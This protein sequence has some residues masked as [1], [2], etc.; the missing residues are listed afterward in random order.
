[1][2]I[3]ASVTACL[4]PGFL[5]AVEL[6]VNVKGSEAKPLFLLE[7]GKQPSSVSENDK[8]L[9][10]YV[11]DVSDHQGDEYASPKDDEVTS[12]KKGFGEWSVNFKFNLDPK[13]KAGEYTFFAKWKQGGDPA[14]CKQTFAVFA[15][16]DASKLEE[17]GKFKLAYSKSWQYEWVMGGKVNF[18][19]DDAVVEIRNSGKAH[20]AKVFDAFI[21]VPK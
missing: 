4:M 7:L 15:G 2:L 14:A 1:M 16:A 21:L 19:A 17:R 13:L 6:P 9:Q 20:D 10:I 3:G 8:S 5:G 11:G 18:K 12:A